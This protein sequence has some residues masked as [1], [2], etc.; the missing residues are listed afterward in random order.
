MTGVELYPA[1]DV[2]DGKAVRL[3]QGDYAAE[4]VYD[5][6]PVAVAALRDQLRRKAVTRQVRGDVENPDHSDRPYPRAY[7]SGR[8]TPAGS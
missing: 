5:D 4:T 3:V 7:A 8:Q 2:R 1:I 6:D